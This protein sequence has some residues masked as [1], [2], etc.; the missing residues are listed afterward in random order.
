MTMELTTA[1]LLLFSVFYGGPAHESFGSS[2][3]STTSAVEEIAVQKPATL[4]EY[5]REYFTDVPLMAEIARCESRFRQLEVNG[6]VL[7]GELS[8]EDVGV[9]QINE[10]YHEDTAK[11]LGLNLH[12]LD[13]N[14]AYAR[15]LYSREGFVPWASSEKC[16][17]NS[18]TLVRVNGFKPS[19][20][21]NAAGAAQT[22]I[23]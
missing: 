4:E 15:W 20:L 16:W 13:G 8:R 7:R 5:V 6:E 21:A 9:M 10:F 1:A 17:R 19:R 22:Q 12:T 14:L 18:E 23:D 11:V 3:K 2:P